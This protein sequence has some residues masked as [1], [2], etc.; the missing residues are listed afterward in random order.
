M[1]VDNVVSTLEQASSGVTQCVLGMASGLSLTGADVRIHSLFGVLERER[2]EVVCPGCQTALYPC[3]AIPFRKFGRSPEMYRAL[4]VAAGEADVIHNHNLWMMPNVYPYLAIRATRRRKGACCKLVNSPHG[5]LTEFALRV[6][7][8]KKK[9]MWAYGQGAMMHA[10]DMFHA[11]CKEEY[12]DI[13]RLGFRQPVVLASMGV[14]IPDLTD[15]PKPSAGRRS[16]LY[17]SRIHSDKRLDLLLD[18]WARLEDQHQ[19]WDLNIY[20]P[21]SGEFPPT[22]VEY[23]RKLG[24]KRAYFKGEVLGADK[25]KVYR[26]ADVF[27]LPTHTENFGLV[28]AEALACGTPAITTEGAPWQ[29]LHDHRCGWWVRE[30]VEGVH[31]ALKDA[32]IKSREELG[33]MGERGRK[34][35]EREYS[36][37]GVG[38]KLLSAYKWIV[39]GGEVPDCVIVD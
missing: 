31:D 13:R 24:L 36:W 30:T 11:T 2:K 28:V 8:W 18:A 32:M 27:V 17:L 7:R 14:A 25:T 23:A 20:G 16:I 38:E 29:R 21:L 22:M 6:S 26:N 33:A 19:D 5:T 34:W 9:L 1:R 35:M 4:K 37:K 10:T 12:D 3:S 39:H 15:V